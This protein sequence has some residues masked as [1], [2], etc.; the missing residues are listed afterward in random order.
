MKQL[1][2][3]NGDGSLDITYLVDLIGTNDACTIYQVIQKVNNVDTPFGLNAAAYAAGFPDIHGVY[4]QLTTLTV[5]KAFAEDNNYTLTEYTPGA[6]PVIYHS[7]TAL[8]VTTA[9]LTAKVHGVLQKETAVLVGTI[10]TATRQIETATVVGT[11]PSDVLQI[12]TAVVVG[13]IE[14]AGVGDATFTI[15][16]SDINA[17]PKAVTVAVANDDTAEQVAAKAVIAINNDADVSL[18]YLAS[19]NGA[20]L[21][22]TRKVVAANDATLNIAYTNDTCLGLT[23][24]A[25]SNDTLAGS[26][27]GAGNATVILTVDGMTGTPKTK[28]VAVAAGDNAAAIAGKIRVALSADADLTA[29]YGVGGEGADIV[30]TAITAAAND[31]TL[32]ISIDNGTC[33][34][35]TQD[36]TSTDTE[37]GVASGAGNAT[38]TVTSAL[39]DAPEVISVALVD[40]DEAAVEIGTKVRAALNANSDITDNFTVGGSGANVSLECKLPAANDATLNIAYTNGTCSGLTPDATSDN[41]TAG[42]AGTLVNQTMA[43]VGGNIPYVWTTASALPP[44]VTFSTAGVLYG[45]PM[46]AATYPIVVRC[47][48]R[49]GIYDE[50]VSMDLVIS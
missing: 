42:A 2:F 44:G 36:L 18:R 47:T 45:L 21:V 31:A 6:A 23:P 13:T 49:F 41:T 28:S 33:S 15:T 8:A 50:S 37:A 11:I 43:A 14:A 9:A 48:D 16:G 1:R 10:P 4:S 24:D 19:S 5:L 7:L 20:N 39:L 3:A 12:E 35:I 22:L 34:G 29:L 30:L 26:L 46:A 32:N 40:G 17:S 38:V 25:T 27:S